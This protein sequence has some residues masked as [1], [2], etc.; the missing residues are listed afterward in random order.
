MQKSYEIGLATHIGPESSGPTRKGGVEALTGERDPYSDSASRGS[1]LL[2][3]FDYYLCRM[4]SGDRLRSRAITSSC[5][6]T[7]TNIGG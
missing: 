3:H 5:H 6:F 1:K 2:D 7:G 4:A